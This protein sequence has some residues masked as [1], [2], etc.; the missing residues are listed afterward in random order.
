M[1]LGENQSALTTWVQDTSGLSCEWGR[2][3][4]RFHTKPF[5]LAY[6]GPISS[7]GHDERTYSY[8]ELTDA[9]E[10]KMLGVRQLTLRLSFRSPDQRLGFSARQLAEDFRLMVESTPSIAFL[11]EAYVSFISTGDLVETD[12]EDASKRMMSQ[13]DMDVVLGLRASK[14]NPNYDGSYIKHVELSSEQYVLDESDNSVVDED[15]NHVTT[16][17]SDEFTV[18][19][20]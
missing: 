5:V 19:G 16:E 8:N 1:N 10:E 18:S 12:Y 2:L 15:G 13:V 20:D 3:P 6:A 7:Q 9:L 4:R 17:A 11:N 14:Q